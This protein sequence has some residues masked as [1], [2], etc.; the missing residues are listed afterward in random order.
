MQV[1]SDEDGPWGKFLSEPVVVRAGEGSFD[2][3]NRF[4]KRESVY[5][6]QDDNSSRGPG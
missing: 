5:S 4:A 3:V 2:S 6:A 1:L